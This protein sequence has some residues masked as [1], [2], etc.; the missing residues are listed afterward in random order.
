MAGGVTIQVKGLREI[1]KKYGKMPKEVQQMVDQEVREAANMH[2]NLAVN[3]A[4]ND[5]NQLRPGIG[6]KRVKLM[7]SEA[8]S[9]APHSAFIEFGTKRKAKIP[10][11]LT[12]YAAQFKG[13]KSG[14]GQK[15]YNAIL[16]WVRRTG[17]AG[18]YSVK[19][20]KKLNSK[21]DKAR[22]EQAAFAIMISILKNGIRPQPFF[23]KH[24]YSVTANLQKKIA[25]KT[26]QVFNK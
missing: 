14:G 15:M 11:D 2:A 24:R 25:G 23:F 4:P 26:K 5:Q 17:I 10:S 6:S 3:A 9:S 1:E 8:Y 21:S 18:R 19:T 20:R 13:K 12:A 16:G 22:E 7:H